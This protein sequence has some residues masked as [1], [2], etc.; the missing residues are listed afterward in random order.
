MAC[1]LL[2]GRAMP[3]PNLVSCLFSCSLVVACS[4]SEPDAAS[5]ATGGS[6]GS[7][8]SAA[9]S[10]GQA[11]STATGTGGASGTGGT[12][13]ASGASGTGGTAGAS[14][15]ATDAAT[16]ALADGSVGAVNV[17]RVR[18]KAVPFPVAHCTQ[19]IGHG[20]GMPDTYTGEIEFLD[21][22]AATKV[23]VYMDVTANRGFVMGSQ[24][25]M[26][27]GFIWMEFQQPAYDAFRFGVG[28]GDIE[29]VWIEMG[30]STGTA[31]VTGRGELA[32]KKRLDADPCQDTVTINSV[33]YDAG[34]P[35]YQAYAKTHCVDPYWLPAQT[36]PFECQ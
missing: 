11:G 28:L 14:G 19:A 18:D 4:S 29:I 32:I 8:A 30:P 34:T 25:S 31:V 12:A 3:R 35:E 33:T 10:A 26:G 2:Y 20:N 21:A 24:T 16:D 7:G 15:A 1:G 17:V 13:G 5:A 9:G 6:A 36:I 23:T 27:S 22:A